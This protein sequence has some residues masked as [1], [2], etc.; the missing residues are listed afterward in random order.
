IIRSGWE[1][2]WPALRPSSTSSLHLNMMSSV[3]GSTRC[4]NSG[5]TL[6]ASQSLS[7][8]RR[9]TS[10]AEFPTR[11]WYPAAIPSRRHVAHGQ[12]A[13]PCLDVNVT[14]RGCL[15][16]LNQRFSR[17]AALEAPE[18]LR[19]NDDDL[20]ASVHRHVLRSLAANL[21]DELAKAGLRILKEPV[22]GA[23]LGNMRFSRFRCAGLLFG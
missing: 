6:R 2:V 15:H 19:G 9:A 12:R 14:M 5:R 22:A 21:A 7:A 16:G 3:I 4:S 23:R 13:A 8:V 1:K 11:Y 18:V 17:D 20:V 10:G